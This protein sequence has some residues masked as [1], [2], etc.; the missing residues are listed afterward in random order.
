MQ[1]GGTRAPG[2]LSEGNGLHPAMLH[3]F[4]EEVA[5]CAPHLRPL[6]GETDR[7]QIKLLRCFGPTVRYENVAYSNWTFLGDGAGTFRP[8]TFAIIDEPVPQSTLIGQAK[9]QAIGVLSLYKAYCKETKKDEEWGLIFV[10][11]AH[12][13]QRK[14]LRAACEAVELAF[15]D[16]QREA[17]YFKNIGNYASRKIQRELGCVPVEPRNKA[18]NILYTG[19]DLIARADY[20]LT[21]EAWEVAKKKFELR[22]E[23]HEAL[24]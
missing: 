20:V 12:R 14:G 6:L 22:P 18:K 11:E 2:V 8:T 1:V 7:D 4:G 10:N 5:E 15:R 3:Y 24:A 19:L 16:P 17:I 13:H 9:P 21:R 23:N